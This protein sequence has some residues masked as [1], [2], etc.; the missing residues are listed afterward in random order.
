MP[1]GK[2]L[3]I[4]FLRSGMPDG[5]QPAIFKRVTFEQLFKTHPDPAKKPFNDH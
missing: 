3:L 5:K 2:P 4:G 1:K